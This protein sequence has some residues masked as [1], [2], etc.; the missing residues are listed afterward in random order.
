MKKVDTFVAQR[1]ETPFIMRRLRMRA[2]D[3][4][5]SCALLRSVGKKS[6]GD[7]KTTQDVRDFFSEHYP[8]AFFP[9][10]PS[11]EAAK[12]FLERR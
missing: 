5:L 6:F 11:E 3:G 9:D 4:V 12:D 1:V 10:G 7:L 8:T 2:A